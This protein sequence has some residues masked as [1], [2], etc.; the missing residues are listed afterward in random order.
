VRIDKIFIKCIMKDGVTTNLIF[1]K[2]QLFNISCM[3]YQFPFIF[4]LSLKYN[5]G[6]IYIMI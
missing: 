1:H 4:I 6:K 3:E 5:N 2:S